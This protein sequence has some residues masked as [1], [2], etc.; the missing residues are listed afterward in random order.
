MT[1]AAVQ[2]RYFQPEGVP[3]E[4]FECARYGLMSTSACSRNFTDAPAAIKR[5]R[6]QHCIGCALG[7]RHAGIPDDPVPAPERS[8]LVYRI[9][10]VRCRRDGRSESSRIIGRLRLVR[11]HTI[12]VSCYNREREI[13][14]GQN[15]KGARP[16]KWRGLFHTRVAYIANGH[17]VVA[18]HPDP[19]IDRIELAL[20][21]LRLGHQHG[22]AWARPAAVTQGA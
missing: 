7:R 8:S 15:A 20:T 13:R 22:V 6:L 11:S 19:V 17:V 18:P 10:C 12:C 21:M 4:Y 3:G 9:A 16:K 2:V 1:I 14:I 5:G